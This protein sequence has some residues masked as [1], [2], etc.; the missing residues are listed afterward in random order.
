M[1]ILVLIQ[2]AFKIECRIPRVGSYKRKLSLRAR[3]ALRWKI[4]VQW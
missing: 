1:P 2:A 3:I 4:A